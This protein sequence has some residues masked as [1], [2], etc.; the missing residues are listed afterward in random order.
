MII[1]FL[2]VRQRE[3]T[4]IWAR[5]KGAVGGKSYYNWE[6]KIAR[7]LSAQILHLF[8]A[9]AFSRPVN[10]VEIRILENYV[11]DSASKGIFH[12]FALVDL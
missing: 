4:S 2:V 10:Y 8:Q 9:L 6:D 7:N 12:L 3:Y 5:E 11:V 1:F